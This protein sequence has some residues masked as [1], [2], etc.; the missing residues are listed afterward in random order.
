MDLKTLEQQDTGEFE[1]KAPD[2]ANTGIVFTLAGP[3]HPAREQL[4]K[5]RRA[6]GLRQLNRKGRAEITE[7]PDELQDMIVERVASCTL[8]WT[9]MSMDGGAY[10]YSQ[11]NAVALYSNPRFGWIVTAISA[12]L[13][14]TEVFMPPQSTS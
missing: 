4:E 11:A 9:D 6:K 1:L 10:P 14:N 3:T 12:A 5:K 8:G 13:D 2:G 7:D